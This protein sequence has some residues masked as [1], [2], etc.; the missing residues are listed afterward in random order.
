MNQQKKKK[1]LFV[2]LSRFN[3][4]IWLIMVVLCVAIVVYSYYEVSHADETMQRNILTVGKNQVS[5]A[6]KSAANFLDESVRDYVENGNQQTDKNSLET[7]LESR[8]M[9]AFLDVKMQSDTCVDCVFFKDTDASLRLIRFQP[10]I[11]YPEKF[12]LCDF[13][14]S[15]TDF[16]NDA[17]SNDWHFV[18]LDGRYYLM[19]FYRLQYG[20]FGVLVGLDALKQSASALASTDETV[21]CLADKQGRIVTGSQRGESLPG[22]VGKSL[23]GVKKTIFEEVDE[24]PLQIVAQRQSPNLMYGMIWIPILFAILG[25]V[26]IALMAK[27]NHFLR[28][29]CMAPIESLLAATQIVR[30]G[31]LDYEVPDTANTEEL[32]ELTTS[33]NDMTKEVKNRKIEVYEEEIQR[34]YV[35]LK[36]LRL[37]L[38]PH[39]YLNSINTILSLSRQGRNQEIQDFIMVLSQY[40]RYIFAESNSPT[41]VGGEIAHTEDFIRLQQIRDPGAIFYMCDVDPV[42][43]DVPMPR[44]LIETFAENI[45][46]HAFDG[47]TMLSIFI[48]AQPIADKDG[49]YCRITVEDS[50]CGFCVEDLQN[51][52]PQ[53]GT[54]ISTIRKTL[55]LTY[56]RDDLLRLSNREEGGAC[57]ELRIPMGTKEAER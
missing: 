6:L 51:Q 50:G 13:L 33:F 1:S 52:Y 56:A 46:K 23:L 38:S 2:I 30:S 39:F 37:Q 7:Y 31:N 3:F 55:K 27:Y 43:R 49:E 54:G 8:R 11:F 32:S 4:V 28:Q 18:F 53:H 21:Y 9:G 19:R 14:S 29:Q 24:T 57:V 5:V 16:E 26:A 42:V 44:L 22:D 10:R 48:R 41:T 20:G 40:L 36:A 25:I 47:E 12:A 45:F 35:E 15:S 17:R 34:Q